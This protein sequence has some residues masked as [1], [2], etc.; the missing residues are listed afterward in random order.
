MRK[1]LFF[2]LFIFTIVSILANTAIENIGSLK[3]Y[4]ISTYGDQEKLSYLKK[5]V[6]DTITLD[7][8]N[9]DYSDLFIKK[10]PDTI[11][12][13][14]RPK[15]NPEEGKHYN[16]SYVYKGIPVDNKIVT[17]LN[18]I[19]NK[20][21]AVLN[22]ESKNNHSYYSLH[23]DLLLTLIDLDD[24]SLVY[25]FIPENMGYN[26]SLKSKKLDRITQSLK[27][28][29]LYM[30]QGYEFSPKYESVTIEDAGYEIK[31]DNNSS[32]KYLRA[33]VN[34]DLVGEKDKKVPF[35]F[36]DSYLSSSKK[37][38]ITKE[39]Y[40]D[41]YTIRRIDSKIDEEI[42]NADIEKPFNFSVI[43]AKPKNSYS[44]ISQTIDPSKTTSYSWYSGSHYAPEDILFVGGELEVKGHKYY[45]M[46]YNG[47]A[48]F[49]KAD[50]VQIQTDGQLKL[51]SLSNSNSEI[52]NW[53]FQHAI[54]LS[55]FYY[56]QKLEKA[57]NELASFKNQGLAIVY[58]NIYDESEYTDG[59]GIN[60]TFY[61]PTQQMIKYIS[62]TFQGYNAVDDPVGKPITKK[63][64]GPIEPDESARYNFEYAW[65]TDIVDY[66]KIRS[67]TVTYKNGSTKT[68]T[69]PSS[70]MFSDELNSIL[71]KTNPVENFD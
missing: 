49:M 42:L 56:T 37:Q 25:F 61:N 28:E 39:E 26:F 10:D 7:F 15:K 50:D 17:P 58:W 53:F 19:N 23:E 63:C 35:N 38:F 45:K 34:L 14:K 36:S 46:A 64:I 59:T 18:E 1:T 47:K 20:P 32:L 16:L 2:T 4:K 67:I 44:H 68:I 11:W 24:L 54:E 30:N 60:I 29:K 48:F 66:A 33:N 13:K 57:A 55:D 70:I 22:V 12:L 9:R 51:D 41:S 6:G 69:R 31:F 3:E 62:I 52:Q 5:F 8:S 27:G 71:E 40:E 65:F 43:L 21:F